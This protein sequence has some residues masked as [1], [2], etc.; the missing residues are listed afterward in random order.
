MLEL[1][2]K[3]DYFSAIALLG[4]SLIVAIL[5]SFNVRL[6]AARVMVSAP[7]L[8]FG[9]NMKCVLRWVCT[10]TSFSGQDSGRTCCACACDYCFL[11]HLYCG[12][13][14]LKDDAE[15]LEPSIPTDEDKIEYRGSLCQQ[16]SV[17]A[18]VSSSSSSSM[19]CHVG[20]FDGLTWVKVNEK[21]GHSLR[22][23]M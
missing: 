20:F 1:T 12:G 15:Y 3:L 6:E 9:G 13:V 11:S 22:M 4:Y 16:T 18:F 10:A 21:F 23:D 8:A 14:L 5:R 17:K 19:A 2:E 7:L